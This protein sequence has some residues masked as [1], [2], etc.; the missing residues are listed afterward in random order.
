MRA[1]V[2]QAMGYAGPI[3]AALMLLLMAGGVTWRLERSRLASLETAL[4]F[5]DLRAGELSRRLDA[6]L[7]AA[8]AA[9]PELVLSEI[10]T[11][12]VGR[13]QGDPAC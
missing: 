4:R 9:D 3:T 6:A 11:R 12:D 7:A 10:A 1:V 2:R 13:G 8:P 5:L